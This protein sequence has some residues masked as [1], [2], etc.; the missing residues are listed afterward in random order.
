ME[1]TK[2]KLREQVERLSQ[3]S[4]SRE[5]G[6]RTGRSRFGGKGD[7]DGDVD[8]L[9]RDQRR[10]RG[11]NITPSPPESPLEPE[12][13]KMTDRLRNQN[14]ILR[15]ELAGIRDEF[16]QNMSP[17][18]SLNPDLESSILELTSDENND[19]PSSEDFATVKEEMRK[20]LEQ[21]NKLLQKIIDKVKSELQRVSMETPRSISSQA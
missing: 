1:N 16:K 18:K 4:Q 10:F 3:S 12:K 17:G 21:E 5:S 19:S 7:R 11:A 20:K 15:E 14:R 2:D 8:F 9:R 13:G 6:I